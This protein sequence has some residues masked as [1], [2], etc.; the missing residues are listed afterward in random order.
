MMSAVAYE[1][2]CVNQAAMIALLVIM[3]T[4]DNVGIAPVQ[5]A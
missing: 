3:P 4:P 1:P 2:L 5:R